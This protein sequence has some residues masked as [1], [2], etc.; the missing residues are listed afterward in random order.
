MKTPG[1]ARDEAAKWLTTRLPERIAAG[2]DEGRRIVLLGHVSKDR[3]QRDWPAYQAWARDWFSRSLP[4]GVTLVENTRQV[5]VSPQVLPTHV[6]FETLETVIEFAGADWVVR[7]ATLRARWATLTSRFPTT[8]T[9][10]LLRRT[11]DWDPVDFDLLL[12]AA[13]WFQSAPDGWQRLTPR[14][15]P[16]E[17]M[18]A[19]WLDQRQWAV[20][21]LAGIDALDLA[22]RPTRIHYTYADP[23]HLDAGG[24]RHDSYTHGDTGA[25]PAYRPRVVLICENKDT[26]V[27]FPRVPGLIVVEGNGAAAPVLLP[28]VPWLADAHQIVY[29]GDVD[30]DGFTILN[31]LRARGIEAASILMDT[32]T[33][34]RYERFGTGT[35]RRNRP[36]GIVEQK[37]LP[38]LTP[39]ERAVY[40][41]LTDPGWT[42]HR[43]IEQERIRL[44]DAVEA[45][46]ARL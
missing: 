44:A 3:L 23:E 15:V 9:G 1:Q 41:R 38:H 13:N 10:R 12:A 18:H 20:A 35:D 21:A 29:W 24:R 32:T 40:D 31:D 43:R 7:A 8:A 14:Q 33:F 27:M 46:L 2:S 39:A 22:T 30:A 26:V 11:S 6:D 4:T 34:D 17:G 5:G 28:Q 36:L 37:A 42:G 16:I 45:I 25:L 19:K